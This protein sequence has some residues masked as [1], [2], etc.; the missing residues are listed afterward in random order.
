MLSPWLSRCG[1][2][3]LVSQPLLLPGQAAELGRFQQAVSPGNGG[4]GGTARALE[5]AH[6]AGGHRDRGAKVF[7][8]AGTEGGAGELGRGAVHLRGGRNPG[9][10]GL[11][12]MAG[13]TKT[14]RVFPR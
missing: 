5:H 12:L 9:T 3:V 13:E 14:I 8:L 1:R 2:L 6:A 4:T 7:P 11:R 10:G